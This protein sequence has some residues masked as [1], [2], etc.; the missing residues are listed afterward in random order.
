MSLKVWILVFTQET[1]NSRG[2]DSSIS[3]SRANKRI[4]R[5]YAKMTASSAKSRSE[6]LTFPNDALQLDL[7]DILPRIQ[8]VQSLKSV[9]A[10]TYP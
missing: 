2:S 9:G 7:S 1:L 3:I 4:S 8:S 5:V 6:I 10:S